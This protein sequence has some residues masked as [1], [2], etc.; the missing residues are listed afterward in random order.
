MKIMI[1]KPDSS[2]TGVLV[3]LAT[4]Y[5]YPSAQFT[6][7]REYA[8]DLDPTIMFQYSTDLQADLS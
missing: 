1:R 7:S 6:H 4:G 8:L 5:R 3:T 2:L